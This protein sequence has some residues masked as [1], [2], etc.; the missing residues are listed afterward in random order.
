MFLRSRLVSWGQV[1][2][3][4][5]HR[6][7]ELVQRRFVFF[8]LGRIRALESVS[9]QCL[10]AYTDATVKVLQGALLAMLRNRE[11]LS[12]TCKWW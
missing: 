7:T 6:S 8:L 1:T 2:L 10:Y 3:A 9:E 11:D 5:R 4:C 12:A